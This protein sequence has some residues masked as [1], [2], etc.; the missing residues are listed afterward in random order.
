M[1]MVFTPPLQ[2]RC[3][4][5][6]LDSRLLIIYSYSINQAPAGPGGADI[7]AKPEATGETG[8]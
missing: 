2:V 6:R 1:L 5:S 7:E 3:F 8:V 4:E